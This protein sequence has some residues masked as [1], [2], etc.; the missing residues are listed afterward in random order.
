MAFCL[1]GPIT[2]LHRR[3]GSPFSGLVTFLAELHLMNGMNDYSHIGGYLD[4]S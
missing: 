1:P 3:L 4:P 2:L